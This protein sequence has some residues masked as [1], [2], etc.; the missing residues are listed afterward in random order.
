MAIYGSA[1]SGS[2]NSVISLQEIN[3]KRI[4]FKE[5]LESVI[6]AYKAILKDLEEY[7]AMKEGSDV[8][9][10]AEDLIAKI[11]EILVGLEGIC[12]K[13]Y[14]Y[15]LAVLSGREEMDSLQNAELLQEQEMDKI[16]LQFKEME[17]MFKQLVGI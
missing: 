10:Q 9:K 12:N 8:G 1:T 17:T 3:T 2:G 15:L 4:Q 14:S 11:N 13:H 7:S 5:G 6:D 16:L